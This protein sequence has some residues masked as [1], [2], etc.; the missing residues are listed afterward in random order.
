MRIA[1]FDLSLDHPLQCTIHRGQKDEE[2]KK[3]KK[4]RSAPVN[5]NGKREKA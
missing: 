1:V 4:K 5:M 3:A 2:I